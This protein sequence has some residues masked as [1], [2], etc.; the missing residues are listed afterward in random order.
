MMDNRAIGMVVAN[1]LE[2]IKNQGEYPAVSLKID[3]WRNRLDVI[4]QSPRT[5][6]GPD[7]RLLVSSIIKGAIPLD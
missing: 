4:A 6:I 3:R 7:G 1:V 5:H 2:E